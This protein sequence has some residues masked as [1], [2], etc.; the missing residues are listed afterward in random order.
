MSTNDID[1]R[2]SSDLGLSADR[3]P[4]DRPIMSQISAPPRTSVAVTG[5]AFLMMS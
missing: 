2:S 3:I 1:S 4:A 5:A